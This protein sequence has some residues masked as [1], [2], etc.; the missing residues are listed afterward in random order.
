MTK[1]VVK[2]DRTVKIQ[3]KGGQRYTYKFTTMAEIHRHLEATNQHYEAYTGTDPE[4]GAEHMY[5]QKLDENGKKL[6]D[7]LRGARIPKPTTLKEYGG[8]LTTCRRYS[9]LM[10]YGLA[11]ED[12]DATDTEMVTPDQTSEA[13]ERWIQTHT[14][15]SANPVSEKQ[16]TLIKNLCD[17]LGKT[18]PETLAI[19]GGINNSAEA[20]KMID[21][22][23]GDLEER[24]AK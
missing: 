17:R 9:L 20:S 12:D 6:G 24:E 13:K 3:T 11:C 1:T 14:A 5:I 18:S 19:L 15:S 2:K 22:L 21:K 10:A 4:T 23:Y 16:R 8:A 7:P